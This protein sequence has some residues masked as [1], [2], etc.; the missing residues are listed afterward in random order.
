MSLAAIATG[1]QAA[2]GLGQTIAGMVKKKPI[3]PEADVPDEVFQNMTDAEY[4]SYIG[5]PPEQRQRAVE[6]IQRAGSSALSQSSSRKGGLGM[7]SQIAQG[8]SNS[9]RSLSEM[10]TNMRYRNIN[11]LYGARD[12]MATEKNRVDEINRNIAYDERDQRNQLIGAGMQNVMGAFGTTSLLDAN[13]D[14]GGE[15]SS[16]WFGR[17]KTAKA[18]FA[19]KTAPGAIKVPDLWHNKKDTYDPMGSFVSQNNFGSLLKNR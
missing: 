12:R 15:G 13:A 18:E 2:I 5:M 8:Q 7:V 16:T 4:W 6:D 11:R 14:E 17:R 10:D 19:Q 9:Y 3:I 1:V